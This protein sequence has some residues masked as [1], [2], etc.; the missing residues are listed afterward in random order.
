MDSLIKIIRVFVAS[1]YELKPERDMMAGFANTLNTVFESQGIS[2]IVVEWENL[3]SSMP[4]GHKQEEYNEKLKTC[5]LFMA[6]FWTKVGKFSKWE[7]KTAR[8][9]MIAGR[10]PHKI[11]VYFKD[12]PSPVN[13]D[14]IVEKYKRFIVKNYKHFP[15][16]FANADALKAHFLLQFIIYLNP[17][18]RFERSLYDSDCL[19]YGFLQIHNGKLY[20]GGKPCIDLMK[21]PFVGNNKVYSDLRRE[22]KKAKSLSRRYASDDHLYNIISNHI[23]E[24][25]EKQRMMEKSLWNTA[26]S[27]TKLRNE[28]HS[29]IVHKA[30]ELFSMGDLEEAQAL[31][32]LKDIARDVERNL[33]LHEM[34]KEGRKGLEYNLQELAIAARVSES[35]MK[36][37]WMRVCLQ[38]CEKMLDICTRLYGDENLKTAEAYY[39]AGTA[40]CKLAKEKYSLNELRSNVL[41]EGNPL[42]TGEYGQH[43]SSDAFDK[44]KQ[45]SIEYLHK[46]LDIPMVPYGDEQYETVLSE[47][48]SGIDEDLEQGLKYLRKALEIKTG[49][50]GETEPETVLTYYNIGVAYF[51]LGQ[52]RNA[53][54]YL[55][56]AATIQNNCLG[57]RHPDVAYTFMSIGDVLTNLE[58][59][60]KALECY[61]V[62][63]RTFIDVYGEN[64]LDTAKAF[65]KIGEAYSYLE[66]WT[67]TLNNYSSALKIYTNL[68]RENSIR[69]ASICFK[70][71]TVYH[72]NGNTEKE[73]EFLLI[74]LRLFKS[75][76][77]EKHLLTATVCDCLGYLYMDQEDWQ[78]ALDYFSSALAI[79]ESILGE[80]HIRTVSNIDSII[81][82]C[83]KVGDT[84]KALDY[85][86]KAL[87]ISKAIRGEKHSL[88]ARYYANVGREY[89]DREDWPNALDYYMNALKIYKS[90]L[91]ED[92]PLTAEFYYLVGTVYCKLGD[93][94]QEA[95]SNLSKSLEIKRKLYGEMHPVTA[96]SY[97][98]LAFIYDHI[99]EPQNCLDFAKYALTIYKETLG[100]NH[101]STA[102]AFDT[103]GVAFGRMGTWQDALDN[104]MKALELFKTIFGESHPDT[105]SAYNFVGKAYGMLGDKKN[106]LINTRTALQLAS[107]LEDQ[108]LINTILTRLGLIIESP[109]DIE[110]ILESLK[111]EID[112]M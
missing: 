71:A 42:I 19:Q 23:H 89:A 107:A 57:D 72:K 34:G 94:W 106:S 70:M 17:N 8:E 80:N 82:L 59:W 13:K 98:N 68:H 96:M 16:S 103:V 93:K 35:R 105:A 97:T 2:V 37:G 29:R 39:N 7:V 52:Y 40:Y 12:R 33:L 14:D 45:W 112:K 51:F 22:I 49:I 61:V 64:H 84:Q 15:D 111:E 11:Y 21:V 50:L 55:V 77:G 44:N 43:G 24:L 1:S 104:G 30:I 38:I 31:L 79:R 27:V 67:N 18:L 3:N 25:E 58:D 75:L 6:L 63:L 53:L 66:D 95:L 69:V 100:E 110:Q 9:E 4:K 10:N 91:G 86:L 108:E 60:N 65:E 101:P 74:A 109:V 26:L 83:Y 36:T 88:T 54:D 99:G 87:K 41:G 20:L 32:N 62:A 28:E 78:N 90:Q 102:R 73:L 48:A 76:F 47:G 92:Q 46:T 5:E 56:K 85:L 81:R